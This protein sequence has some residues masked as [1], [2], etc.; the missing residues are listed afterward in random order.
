MMKVTIMTVMR[1]NRIA[2]T[3]PGEDEGTTTISL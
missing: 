2:A 1:T 3:E